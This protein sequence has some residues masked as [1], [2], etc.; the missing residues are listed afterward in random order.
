MK[1]LFAFFVVFLAI[2]FGCIYAQTSN[3]VYQCD[4]ENPLEHAKWERNAGNQGPKCANK[5][6]FGKPGSNGGDYGLFVSN[7]SVSNNYSASALSVVA[8]REVLLD[9][10]MYEFSFDWRASGWQDSISDIDGLY[11]CWV[12]MTKNTNSLANANMPAFLTDPSVEVLDFGRG[13]TK[14][15]Q[16]SWNTVVDTIVSDGTPHKIVFVWRNGVN[17]SYPPAACIDN[18]LIMPVGYCYKPYDLKLEVNDMDATFSWSGEAEAYDVRCYNGRTK[19]WKE[20]QNVKDKHIVVE[21]VEEGI[22]TYYVR[23]RCE[24]IDGTWVSISQF[25]YYPGARCIDYMSLSSE[26]CFTGR[27]PN[28]IDN[29]G[30]SNVLTPGQID[31]GYQNIE[32]RHTIHY[33]IEERDPRTNGQLRTVPEGEPASVRLGNW[34]TNGEMERVEYK[35]T[36]DA[37]SS[38]VLILKYAVVLQ[39]PDHNERMQPKFELE[40]LKNGAPIDKN[41]CGEAKFTAGAN[42]SGEGWHKFETGWWKDWTTVSINLREHDGEEVVVRLTTYDCA[43]LGHFGYAYFTLD[44]SDGQIQSSACGDVENDTLSGPEG[45]NYRWYKKSEKNKTLSQEQTYIISTKD[46]A[47]YCL[48]V[49]QPTNSGCYYTLE[50]SG[51]QRYPKADGEYRAYVEECMNKVAFT[52]KS[53]VEQK[54]A[55]SSSSGA[56]AECDILWDFGDGSTSSNANPIHVYPATGGKF[57]ATLSASI[58]GGKCEELKTFE[59]VLPNVTDMRDTIRATVCPGEGYKLGENFYVVTGEYA[60]TI[61]TEYGCD[62]ITVLYLN[63]LTADTIFDT[64]CSTDVLIVDNVRVTETG[65]YSVKSSLGCDSLIY[66]VLVNESLVLDVADVISVCATDENIIIPYGLVS[67]ELLEFGISFEDE[68]LVSASADKL[69]PDNLAMV[70]PMISGVEPNRYKA[71]LT[72]G[73]LACG[74]DD[75]D[76]LI[77]VYYPDSVIAQRWNDVLAVRNDAYNGGY[78]FVEYQW[79]KDGAMIDG[80]TSSILYVEGGL[81]FDAEYSVMLTRADGVKEMVC[82]VQPTQFD[83]IQEEAI[84]VFSSLTSSSA[85]VKVSEPANV[86]MWN[87]MGLLVDEYRVNTGENVLSFSLRSGVYLLEF[88]FDNGTRTTE[89]IVIR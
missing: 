67:G 7:D 62:N 81:D 59:F 44:C 77:D 75:I 14:L 55:S 39:D 16:S 24:G 63:V 49:I 9:S 50:T 15:S 2:G 23:S 26:N 8:Y 25:V 30:N 18:I 87:S 85:E 48:D 6:Y 13:K 20:Y 19:K 28:N 68:A 31:K 74:A 11:V 27:N 41:G 66:D 79:Y 53:Y 56:K 80:E 51:M 82:A 40:I 57:T 69:K 86:R 43:E 38:A 17:G 4:F 42:T 64:I 12:P 78:E 37:A 71:R 70:I 89:R 76:V 21:G 61:P 83:N 5:W 88:I 34:N 52:N 22:C 47:V 73:E 58:G 32:S 54:N 72:F 10:G 1:K 29:N 65:Q 60:D 36:V 84:V 35:Y 3:I 33:D 46:T 45:F